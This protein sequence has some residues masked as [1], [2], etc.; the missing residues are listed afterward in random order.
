MF[1]HLVALAEKLQQGTDGFAPTGFY[2]PGQPIRWVVHFTPGQAVRV[3]ETSI[4]LPRPFAG[5]TSGPAA[6]LLVDRASY[7]L[8]YAKSTKGKEAS[9]ER[10]SQYHAK[11]MELLRSF[12]QWDGLTDAHL[13]EVLE[14]LVGLLEDEKVLSQ[15][16]ASATGITADDWV[17]FM[18]EWGPLKGQHLYDHPLAR[19][20]WVEEL[21]RRTLANGVEGEC[22]ICGRQRPL[23]R[24]LPLQV[25]GTI[26]IHSL[27]HDAFPSFSLSSGGAQIGICFECGDK[28][29]RALD[30]LWSHK[31]H[32]QNLIKD[33]DSNDSLKNQRAVFW[34]KEPAALETGEAETVI[35]LTMLAPVLGRRPGASLSQLYNLLKLPWKPATHALLLD[36]NAFFLAVFSPN[37]TRLALREWIQVSLEELKE[38]L[39][40]F[41]NAVQIV[42]EFGEP[43]LFS[44]GDLLD[45]LNAGNPNVLRN[46]LRTA[47]LGWAPPRE[48]LTISVRL[49]RNPRLWIA[50]KK[51]QGSNRDPG[52]KKDQGKEKRKDE[53]EE[54]R[55]LPPLPNVVAVAK[56]VLVY[57]KGDDRMVSLDQENRSAAYL[58]GRLLAIMEEAQL[59][60][61]QY[62]VNRT[63]VERFYGAA[64]TAP[65]ATFGGLIRQATTAHLP[66]LGRDLNV[67]MEEVMTK[68][69]QA[70]G[71]PRILTLEEQAE[72]GLG[73]YHQRAAFR[74]RR[75]EKKQEGEMEQETG[76]V[77]E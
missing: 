70:G 72:F 3:E 73:F 23:L 29:T 31:D 30:Y 44:I 2:W 52:K 32:H 68:I 43:K 1:H 33:P 22:A 67:E 16:R 28:A 51:D 53:S 39:R 5:R 13:R 21:Q 77:E 59:R 6:S 24:K 19:V 11:F 15:I 57:G 49:M 55:R 18:P 58:C 46:L 62:K 76:G 47:F 66:E 42:D 17:S 4:A 54:K 12:L 27:N 45:V 63:L 25:K 35:D 37:K 40:R 74:A 50:D 14:V 65:A 41:L 8:G 56:L 34:L 60:A 64:S 7:A 26:P 36:D 38:H 48:L 61:S 9:N 71:F 69:D 20:F 75:K 10:S